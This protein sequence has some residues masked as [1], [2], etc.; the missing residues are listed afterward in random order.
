MK[1]GNEIKIFSTKDGSFRFAILICMDYYSER[2]KLYECEYNQKIGID[3][4]FVPSINDNYKR[5]QKAA[6]SDCENYT[7]DFVKV[8]HANDISAVFG[9]YHKD[10][11]ERLIKLGL[12]PDDNCDYK[13]LELSGENLTIFELSK[14][15]IIVPTPIFSRPRIFINERMKFNDKRWKNKE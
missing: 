15:K 1:Q 9:R 6:D 12:R 13:L 8:C 5:F 3:I 4:L 2:W 14:E 10:F 11:K 7:T